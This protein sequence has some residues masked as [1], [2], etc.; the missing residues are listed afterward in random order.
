MMEYTTPHDPESYTLRELSLRRAR[1]GTQQGK[2]PTPWVGPESYS[3]IDLFRNT[4]EEFSDAEN[5]MYW[6]EKQLIIISQWELLPVLALPVLRLARIL[7]ATAYGLVAGIA[8]R[9]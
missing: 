7:N 4:L 2:S 9:L 3:L 6:L 8:R 1:V 5:Y